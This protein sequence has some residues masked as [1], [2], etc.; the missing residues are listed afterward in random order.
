ML[1][2]LVFGVG[3]AVCV[4]C[5][6]LWVWMGFAVCEWVCGCFLVWVAFDCVRVCGLCIVDWCFGLLSCGFVA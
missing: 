4:V 2:G 1:R 3:C 5:M 6:L